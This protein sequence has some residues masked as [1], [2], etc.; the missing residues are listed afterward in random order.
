MLLEAMQ[1]FH[2]SLLSIPPL[3]LLLSGS[4]KYY[5]LIVAI[6][7]FVSAHWFFFKGECVLSYFYK[8]FRDC[9]YKLGDTTETDDMKVYGSSAPQGILS[10]LAAVSMLRMALYLNYNVPLFVLIETI[11]IFN[12]HVPHSTALL[13]PLS[14]YFL[15][16]SRYLVPGILSIL[17]LSVIVRRFDQVPCKDKEK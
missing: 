9:N 8:K 11:S 10:F 13:V 7:V 12:T 3:F 17:F 1:L 6:F 16:D 5:E 2:W 15:K 4:P 14:L